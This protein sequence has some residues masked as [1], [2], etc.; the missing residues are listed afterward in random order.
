M[1]SQ[2]LFFLY[3][4]LFSPISKASSAPARAFASS[5]KCPQQFI[6]RHGTAVEPNPPPLPAPHLPSKPPKAS[7]PAPP[8][9]PSSKRASR[10][11]VPKDAKPSPQKGTIMPRERAEPNKPA[12]PPPIQAMTLPD[13]YTPELAA[14][15]DPTPL[16]RVLHLPSPVSP[17]N[18]AH[19][20]PHLQT[21]P[22]THHFDTFT[23]VRD[24]DRGGFQAEASVTLMKA[25]RGL[26][27]DNLHLAREGLVSKSDVENATYLFRAACSELRTEIQNGRKAE[28]E[29]MRTGRWQLHHET[30][31]L[32]QRLTQDLMT[33][34]DELKGMFDDRKMVTRQEQR[35]M[36]SA[37][38]ELNYRITVSLNSD[39]KS[40]VEGLRWVLTRRAAMAI[41]VMAFL[42][43]GSLRAAS[44]NTHN[45]EKAAAAAAAT[46]GGPKPDSE[47][48]IT[49]SRAGDATYVSLG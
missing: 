39:S 4:N 30:D 3:P 45:Q 14:H 1:A 7:E 29:K 40:E 46:S 41:V 28:T 26:L 22:Y 20:P 13:L 33:L 12:P 18:S 9:K 48:G 23:L 17:D 35:R 38:Q 19:K 27:A 47:S 32:N 11:S 31:I 10:P 36:E 2:R 43:L 8:E 42:I 6:Q 24:L 37:I 44:V 21:P 49:P 25:V 15:S 34:R 5:A 16:Q